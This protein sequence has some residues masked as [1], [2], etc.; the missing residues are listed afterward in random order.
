MNLSAAA[1]RLESHIRAWRAEGIQVSEPL[2][3]ADARVVEVRI[4][5]P[6]WQIPLT[7]IQLYESGLACALYLSAAETIEERHQVSSL[8]EWS[9]VLTGATAR[10]AR[11]RHAQARLLS[12]TCTT[13]WLDW[14]HGR[15][16]LLP[17]GLLR[18]RGD[19]MTTLVNG[20]GSGLTAL[21]P[22]RPITYDPATVLAAHPTNKLIPFAGM[23]TARLHGGVTTSGL[24]VAMTDGTR[25]KLLWMNSDPARG[26]LRERLLPLL[27]TRLAH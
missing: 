5:S 7:V 25:H 14:I 10:A 12:S 18:V 9:T 19:L 15:L 27:G 13:G 4:A 1:T 8:D 11:V 17:E 3:A 23:A 26:L 2:W 6:S 24:E 22:Y 21:D 20:F 16:W